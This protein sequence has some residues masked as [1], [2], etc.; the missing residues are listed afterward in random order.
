MKHEFIRRAFAFTT[1]CGLTMGQVILPALTV[2]LPFV[3]GNAKAATIST[4]AIRA[5]INAH[6]NYFFAEIKPSDWGL[7]ADKPEVQASLNLID[8][9]K[10]WL[11]G[12]TQL[13]Y[14]M[15][16]FSNAEKAAFVE[17]VMAGFEANVP[18]QLRSIR[19]SQLRQSYNEEAKTNRF[20]GLGVY[21]YKYNLFVEPESVVETHILALRRLSRIFAQAVVNTDPYVNG[22]P[23][24]AWWEANSKAL[25]QAQKT[26]LDFQQGE[27]LLEFAKSVWRGDAYDVHTNLEVLVQAKRNLANKRK[28]VWDLILPNM[29]WLS[30]RSAPSFWLSDY[31]PFFYFPVGDKVRNKVQA[32]LNLEIEKSSL[33]TL[34][35]AATQSVD[36]LNAKGYD[37]AG[38]LYFLMVNMADIF[39]LDGAADGLVSKADDAIRGGR[40]SMSK[41]GSLADEVPTGSRK[42]ASSVDEAAE[43]A[44]SNRRSTSSDESN[45][46]SR[47]RTDEEPTTN[48]NSKCGVGFSPVSYS[49]NTHSGTDNALYA[50]F[51]TLGLKQKEAAPKS[52]S[53]WKQA[54]IGAHVVADYP[55]EAEESLEAGIVF[56]TLEAYSLQQASF[57]ACEQEV[58][59]YLRRNS[60]LDMNEANTRVI[61]KGMDILAERRNSVWR[62]RYYPSE[63]IELNM[64]MNNKS[65]SGLTPNQKLALDKIN[66]KSGGRGIYFNNEGFPDFSPFKYEGNLGNGNYKV[67]LKRGEWKGTSADFAKANKQAG[68]K[69]TPKGYTWHHIEDSFE[70]ILVDRKVHSKIGH[71]GG[72][73]TGG[74]VIE[75]VVGDDY[76]S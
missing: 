56:P 15:G 44:T 50:S 66:S 68:L 12:L 48:R 45:T 76:K 59:E 27:M 41:A 67:T 22:G 2:N 7:Q 18:N 4:Q 26:W 70:L 58:T 35:K 34:Q 38:D 57:K 74:G 13:R 49:Y 28:G 25:K 32:E 60:D 40:G 16:K 75:D 71:T 23:S 54:T 61:P 37:L 43:G 21:Y 55:V 52:E 62:G 17:T 1:A 24:D 29:N 65:G 8:H 3:E 6:T 72:A 36:E 10:N 64:R 5:K 19:A 46:N 53:A 51:Q 63:A 9:H 11:L 42:P 73:A 30:G 31:S 33:P 69:E 14:D 20:D 39:F 47:K